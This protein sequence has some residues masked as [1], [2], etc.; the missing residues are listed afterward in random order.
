MTPV[1]RRLVSAIVAALLLLTLTA[2]T[3]SADELLTECVPYDPGL[4]SVTPAFWFSE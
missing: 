4:P 3:A 2:S 1:R